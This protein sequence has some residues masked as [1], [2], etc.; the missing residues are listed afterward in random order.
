MTHPSKAWNSKQTDRHL[1]WASCWTFLD[2]HHPV[3]KR[4]TDR[5]TNIPV[6]CMCLFEHC[7][8][9]LILCAAT[10][11]FGMHVNKAISIRNVRI[12]ATSFK[13][14]LGLS[15]SLLTAYVFHVQKI[16]ESSRYIP[17]LDH[18]NFG[19]LKKLHYLRNFQTSQDVVTWNVMIFDLLKCWQVQKAMEIFWQIQQEGKWPHQIS[20]ICLWAALQMQ[21]CWDIHSDSFVQNSQLCMPGVGAWRCSTSFHLVISLQNNTAG[22]HPP[23]LHHGN[24]TLKHLKQMCENST[25]CAL[26]RI[27]SQAFIHQTSLTVR[28]LW[29]ILKQSVPFSHISSICFTASSPWCRFGGWSDEH[30]LHDWCIGTL[31]LHGNLLGHAESL[32]ETESISRRCPVNHMWWWSG[33]L[34]HVALM[35]VFVTMLL[36][37]RMPNKVSSAVSKISNFSFGGNCNLHWAIRVCQK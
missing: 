8:S 7:L 11:I 4:Q 31:H 22:I 1:L 29:N 30:S 6:V 17:G 16:A 19:V 35:F 2:H 13:Q 37:T 36:K 5:Q 23:N 27:T 32:Q 10:M 14:K 20:I 15:I 3:S 21:Q 9:I 33:G 28:K 24:E 34:M 12:Q 18:S 26:C 25:Q